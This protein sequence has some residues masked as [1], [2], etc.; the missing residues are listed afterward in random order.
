MKFFFRPNILQSENALARRSDL[1]RVLG[2]HGGKPAVAAPISGSAS[3]GHATGS[4]TDE[5]EEK[6][7]EQHFWWLAE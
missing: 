4:C 5:S 1:R 2:R 3:P 6:E 7:V